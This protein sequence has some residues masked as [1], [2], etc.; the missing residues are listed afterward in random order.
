MG[1]SIVFFSLLNSV[2]DEPYK[3]VNAPLIYQTKEYAIIN[4]ATTTH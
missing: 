1:S 4:A 2:N 3:F